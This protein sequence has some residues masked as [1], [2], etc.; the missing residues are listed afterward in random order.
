MSEVI[1]RF[2]PSPTGFLHIGNTRTALFSYMYAKKYE[3]KFL[4]RVEDTD[5]KRSTQEA[6]D[7]ILNGLSW[8]GLN[9]DEEPVYQ[10]QKETNHKAIAEKLLEQGKAYKCYATKEELEQ[11]RQAAQ[12]EGK[13]YKYPGIWRD[14]SDSEA[15]EGQEYVIRIKAPL[16]GVMKINDMVQGEIS[17]PAKDL[18]DFV[19][20]RADGSPTYM[21]AVV[22]DDHDMGVTD[23][24]R[25][26]DH[27]T[28]SFKQQTLYE[29]L[30]W[31]MPKTAHVPLIHGSDGTKLSKRHGALSVEAY[32]E[33]GYLPEAMINYLMGLGWS[34]GEEETIDFAEAIERF[35]INK[36]GKS[37]SRFDFEKLNNINNIYLRKLDSKA[38][39][40]TAKPFLIDEFGEDIIDSHFLSKFESLATA[41]AERS[42]TLKSLAENAKFIVA[43]IPYTEKAEK[44]LN[45]GKEN[46]AG[47][48][49]EFEKL[50]SWQIEDI[51]NAIKSFGE[52][53]DLKAG[54]YMPAIRAGVCG[55]MEAPSL[56]L[57]LFALGKDEVLKRLKSL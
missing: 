23:I 57:V 26:D 43:R 27:M 56:D 30:G 52:K 28:N 35:D 12:A 45:K 1:T 38:L 48:I 55:T 29:A 47:V 19:I 6:I 46:I 50:D 11:H 33:M 3:G 20:L 15:P 5:K 21:L 36:I 34:W 32:K 41:L 25:G 22:V 10:S 44:M 4:L 37:P 16:D 31:Q 13:V 17:Y 40:A 2:A 9:S 14:K 24:I 18:D 8:L 49:E 39:T 54:Q 42:D 53:N 7:V 51:S